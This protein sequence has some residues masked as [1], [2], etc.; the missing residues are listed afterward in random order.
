M[1]K[2]RK[3]DR[4]FKNALNVLKEN[5]QIVA[6]NTGYMNEELDDIKQDIKTIKK[7][8]TSKIP[9]ITL[10]ATIIGIIVAIVGIIVANIGTVEKTKSEMDTFIDEIQN[11][12]QEESSN[13]ET[14]PDELPASSNES[15]SSFDQEDD[16]KSK[17]ILQQLRDKGVPFYRLQL[18]FV[19]TAIRIEKQGGDYLTV[20]GDVI[21]DLN[22]NVLT[23]LNKDYDIAFDE[24][25]VKRIDSYGV[26]KTVVDYEDVPPGNYELITNI[27]GYQPLTVSKMYLGTECMQGIVQEEELYWGRTIDLISNGSD[28]LLPY[29]ITV[30]DE[31]GNGLEGGSFEFKYKEDITQSGFEIGE[32]GRIPFCFWTFEGEKITL[33][34]D[35]VLNMKHRYI[36]EVTFND[37]NNPPVII[38][39]ENGSVKIINENEYLGFE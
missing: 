20:C 8:T 30:V 22:I 11:V 16:G 33:F 37:V 18:T 9:I 28:L 2:N 17:L 6:E 31:Y 19:D 10:I 5:S 12:E 13:T 38:L 25:K 14:G 27:E 29:Y 34:V 35:N 36:C 23:L 1:G 26:L 7:S 24:Y 32:N 21:D 4:E 39:Y 3:R 15:G